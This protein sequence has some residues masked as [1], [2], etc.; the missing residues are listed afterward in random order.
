MGGRG[1]LVS[2]IVLEVFYYF[3]II[4]LVFVGE[5]VRE[6]WK[7]SVEIPR[8]PLLHPA[9]GFHLLGDLSEKVLYLRCV[10]LLSLF[11]SSSSS[12]PR[13]LATF[14]FIYYFLLKK[15]IYHL[16]N[17]ELYYFIKLI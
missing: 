4:I 11:T 2:S 8:L 9:R 3:I 17:L 12:S 7:C 16:V 6:S 15:I 14:I 5:I 10:R 13:F 1:R